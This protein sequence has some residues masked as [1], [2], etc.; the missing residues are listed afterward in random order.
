MVHRSQQDPLITDET[1]PQHVLVPAKNINC[2]SSIQEAKHDPETRRKEQQ[3][4]GIY[5]DDEYDYLQHLRGTNSN[6]LEWK[7]VEDN[8]EKS[9]KL[10]LP[11]S[12]FAS[13]VEEDEGLLHKLQELKGPRPDWD[14]DVVAALDDDFDFD[15]PE[16]QLEVSITETQ[17]L[18]KRF[19]F[20]LI[21]SEKIVSF[22]HLYL[23]ENAK[24]DVC[25][26]KTERQ[27]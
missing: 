1:A 4:Y 10:S 22:I 2:Q 18:F 6:S 21:Q 9:N 17:K 16:N 24:F 20:G 13:E 12:V 19:C 5:F 23:F 7:M 3:K 27:L 15:D 14:P 26:R 25:R 11:S 8:H